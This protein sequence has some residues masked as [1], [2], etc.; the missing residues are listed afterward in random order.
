MAQNKIEDLRNH[1]FASLERLGEEDLKG[2]KLAEEVMRSKAICSISSEIVESAK[3]E[4]DLLKITGGIKSGS[5]F[6]KGVTEQRQ[7]G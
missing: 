7:I 4:I 6:F 1:L 3:V 5:Q 2:E